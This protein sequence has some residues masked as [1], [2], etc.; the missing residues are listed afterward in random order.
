MH[1]LDLRRLAAGAAVTLAS[2]LAAPSCQLVSGIDGMNVDKA[3]GGVLAECG[4]MGTRCGGTCV[5]GEYTPPGVCMDDYTCTAQPRDCGYYDCDPGGTACATSCLPS[6]EGCVDS[7]VCQSP[8]ATCTRCG[9]V[10]EDPGHCSINN[11]VITSSTGSTTCDCDG[12][13]CVMNATSRAGAPSPCCSTR[14]SPP[15]CSSATMSATALS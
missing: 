12:D 5:D 11:T 1:E 8:S 13:T 15:S 4:P 10:P 3:A 7:A 14:R 2:S 6:G 9:S